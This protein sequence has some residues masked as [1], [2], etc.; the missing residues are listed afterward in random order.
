L[1]WDNSLVVSA[2]PQS[3]NSR[4]LWRHAGFL[5]LWAGQTVSLFGSRIT[6]LA[7]PLT[8]VMVLHASAAQMG[9][10]A[11]AGSAAWLVVGLPA[12]V[13]V[14]RLRRRPLMVAADLGRALL[15]FSVP[16]AAWRGGLHLEQLYLV[17]F[18]VGVL[19]VVFDVAYQSWLPS[20]IPSEHL[21]EGNSKLEM[22]DSVAQIAGP[23]LGGLL[24]QALTAPVA[25]L[26]DAL[27]FLVSALLLGSICSDEA[28]PQ[29]AKR[30]SMRREIAE[31]VRLVLGNPLLRALAASSATFN[32]FD[33]VLF[34]VYILYMVRALGLS[35]GAIG[36]IFGL[37]GVGGLLGALLVG[38]IT[39]RVGLGR[40]MTAAV[41][42]AALAEILIAAA[43]GPALVAASIL[44]GAE[45]IVEFGAVLFAINAVTLRQM[46]TPEQ[47]RGRV[48][49]TSRFATWGVGPVGALLGGA[50][51]QAIGLR[52]TVLLAGLGTLLAFPW[53]ALLP[54]GDK[55]E[56]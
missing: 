23:G 7:L 29:R 46:R 30:G 36:L 8:A 50:L 3:P 12:G 31:G 15:L 6:L 42:L 19:T 47:L 5:T 14:D 13:W 11:A 34:S 39:R 40:T 33:S 21:V 54:S 18:L 51:G 9:L 28:A 45:A 26:A 32:L 56:V 22:S 37:G 55:G 25:I 27:S 48:N 44:T 2:L 53:L 17:Q 10:L 43:S 38:P 4:S 1:Q 20:L 16:L 24:V 41:I 35:A 49:A 52:Q